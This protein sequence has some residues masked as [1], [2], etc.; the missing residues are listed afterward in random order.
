MYGFTLCKYLYFIQNDGRNLEYLNNKCVI[1]CLLHSGDRQSCRKPDTF[2]NQNNFFSGCVIA[3]LHFSSILV[4]AMWIWPV[5]S[6][7]ELL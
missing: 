4:N 2:L 3:L 7:L 1:L 6:L 5:S